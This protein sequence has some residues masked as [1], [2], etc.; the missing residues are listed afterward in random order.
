MRRKVAL[1]ALLVGA[2][3]M[4]GVWGLS[5]ARLLHLRFGDVNHP[6]P[7]ALYLMVRSGQIHCIHTSFIPAVSPIFTADGRRFLGFGWCSWQSR[8][9]DERD[10]L[11]GWQISVPCWGVVALFAFYPALAFIRGPA[12]RWRRRKRGLC[13]HCGYNLTGLTEPRCPECGSHL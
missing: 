1:A 4:G 13:I 6:K 9:V 12:R 10:G 3:L 11:K 2:T 5:Y 7:D 8:Q